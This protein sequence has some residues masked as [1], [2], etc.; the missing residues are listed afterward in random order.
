ML[1]LL[2]AATE[3]FADDFIVRIANET[4][5]D[6]AEVEIFV[7][8][9]NFMVKNYGYIVVKDVKTNERVTTIV[10]ETEITTPLAEE[11]FSDPLSEDVNLDIMVIAIPSRSSKCT[12]HINADF[13]LKKPKVVKIGSNYGLQIPHIDIHINKHS[14]VSVKC[15]EKNIQDYYMKYVE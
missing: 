4:R 6:Y 5:D 10:K 8:P 13:V 2:S 3:V 11:S 14:Y 15:S 12:S 7:Y 1:L 9:V